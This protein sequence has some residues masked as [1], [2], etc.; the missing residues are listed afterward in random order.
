MLG[1][2]GFEA[3]DVL[4]LELK[5]GGVFDGDDALRIRDVAG[6]DIEERGFPGAGAAGDEQIETALDHGGEQFEHLLGQGLI[7]DHVARGNGIAAEAADGEA[8]AVEGERRNDGVDAGAVLEAGI[9]HG[10]RLVD[11]AADARDDAV[12]D[13]HQ[14]LVVFERRAGDFELA[15]AL[16]VDAVKAVDED[17][18]DGGVLEQRLERAEAED[19]VEDFAG[20]ALALGEAEGNRLAVHRIAN[21]DENFFAGGV[22]GGAAEFFEVEAIEDLAVQVGFYL[23][24][25]AALE[26][27][28]VGHF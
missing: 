5:F 17:V 16:D 27:L 6:E 9:D 18:G 3:D 8:C 4:L 24:V 21:E 13:L 14:V 12:D 11:A 15:G 20:E 23:L 10:R 2:A 22:A 26:G 19:L 1:G 7:L 28:K 25:F